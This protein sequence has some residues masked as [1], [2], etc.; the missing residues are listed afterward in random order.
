MTADTMLC[1]ERR[2]TPLRPGLPAHDEW[3]ERPNGDRTCSFCGSLH[4]DDYLR[5]L[6]LA[7]DPASGVRPARSAAQ[8]VS[9]FSYSRRCRRSWSA[10]QASTS[11]ATMTATAASAVA[12]TG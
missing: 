2:N 11:T 3:R 4:P 9:S 1:P 5:L 6:E 12:S 8:A 10:A 7:N